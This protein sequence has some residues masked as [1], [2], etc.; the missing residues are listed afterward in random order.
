MLLIHNIILLIHNIMLLIR[1]IMTVN[2]EY[3]DSYHDSLIHLTM[4]LI[5]SSVTQIHFCHF[6]F[7]RARECQGNFETEFEFLKD[8]IKI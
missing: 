1:N 7:M 8:L 5:R 2:T 4:N 3:Y 6:D